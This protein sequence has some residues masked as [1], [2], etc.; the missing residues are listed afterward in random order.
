MLGGHLGEVL[1]AGSGEGGT[2][3]WGSPGAD[4]ALSASAGLV[5]GRGRAG[6]DRLLYLCCFERQGGGGGEP[7]DPLRSEQG[8]QEKASER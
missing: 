7:D 6:G 4:L 3:H 1:L 5:T 2:P 8:L